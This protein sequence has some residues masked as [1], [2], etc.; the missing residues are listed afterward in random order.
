M[1]HLAGGRFLANALYDPIEARS[2]DGRMASKTEFLKAIAFGVIDGARWLINVF[3]G[4][5]RTLWFYRYAPRLL[6]APHDNLFLAA[7]YYVELGI[8]RP[9]EERP[10]KSDYRADKYTKKLREWIKG[11]KE[12]KED[13]KALFRKK[14]SSNP[15]FKTFVLLEWLKKFGLAVDDKPKSSAMAPVPVEDFP[16]L[17][18]SRTSIKHYFDAL[19]KFQHANPEEAGRFALE[20]ETKVGY[21]APLFL[22]TGLINRFGEEDGWKRILNNYGELIADEKNYSRELRELRSF[23]FNCWLLWGPSI[24][25]CSC[26]LWRIKKEKAAASDLLIQYGYGD[27]NNSIDILIKGGGAQ[28]FKDKLQGTLRE[29]EGTLPTGKEGRGAAPTAVLAARYRV[30][31]RFRWAPTLEDEIASAQLL[32]CGGSI[33]ELR[34]PG[35][36]RVVLECQHYDVV[37][38]LEKNG[39][40]ASLQPSRYYSAYLWIMFNI[41]D[42]HGR[43]FFDRK[44]KNLLVFF[45]HANIADATTYRSLKEQLVTKALDTLAKVLTETEVFASGSSLRSRELRISYACALDDSY[46]GPDH[47]ILFPPSRENSKQDENEPIV[48]ILR[49]RIDELPDGPKRKVL[50]SSR[51]SIPDAA[52]PRPVEENPYSSCHLPEIVEQFYADL[53]EQGDPGDEEPAL[54]EEDEKNLRVSNVA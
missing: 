15:D 4:I 30:K 13:I 7:R 27:E 32:I 14:L 51:F 19:A 37:K 35:D 21:I 43:P 9:Q 12:R 42:Q 50:L 18:D 46:C 34:Q 5:V 26:D 29:G 45:E 44:W 36:A 17:D 22:I 54:R 6:W 52:N 49:R 38:E 53:S 47:G 10:K 41:H 48:G 11:E 28:E 40:G 3:K 1:G 23:M 39:A 24:A 20:V 2:V 16:K 31:G 25:P 8:L 33:P